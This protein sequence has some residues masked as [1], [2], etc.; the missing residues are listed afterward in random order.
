MA[1]SPLLPEEDRVVEVE[2]EPPAPSKTY[3]L[4]KEEIGGLI[5]GEEALKQFIVKAMGT[6]RYRFLI[7]DD[8]YGSELDDLIGDD[9]S[10]E[11]LQAEIPRIIREALVYDD[12]IEDVVD[13][14][15]T[16]DSNKLY[17]GFRVVTTDGTS[18]TEEVTF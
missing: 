12:R 3:R 6:A 10:P 1:L 18:I 9:F 4:G 11:L 8:Q 2:N 14:E 5:D 16:R 15:I 17:V 7:Y 13:F